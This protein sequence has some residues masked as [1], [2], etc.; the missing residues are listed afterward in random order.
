MTGPRV[1]IL[2]PVHNE[3]CLLP[4]ALASLFRQTLTD[5]ELV[6]INDGSTDAT[7]SILD[8][9]AAADRRVRVFHRPQQGLVAT[10]NDGLAQ[11]HAPLVARMDGDDICHPHRLE[12]QSGFLEIHPEITLAACR[13]RHNDI[14]ND[15]RGGRC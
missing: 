6:A 12:R 5:W 15:G 11:C 3:E 2:L 9:A 4:A 13:V 8:A 10:L 14:T 7:G 1:S